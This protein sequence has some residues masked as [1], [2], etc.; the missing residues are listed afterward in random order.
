MNFFEHQ[1]AARRAS[2]RMVWLF[3]ASVL[4]IVVAIDLVLALVAGIAGVR[5]TGG[6][7]AAVTA[8]VLLVIFG[9]TWWQIRQ[10]AGGGEAVAALLGAR[11][12]D[13]S[14]GDLLERRLAN[15]VEE[16]A[17]ASGIAV[18]RCYLLEH[19][20]FINACAA[21]HTLDNAAVIVTRGA[22][23]RLSRD[24]LQGV[25]AHEFAH[26]VN[27]DMRLNLRLVGVTFGLLVVALA[28][29]KLIEHGPDSSDARASIGLLLVG[30]VLIAL[31]W[32]GVLCG[33][34][35]K[36]GVSRD[37][38]YLADASA[39]QFT[40]NPDSIGGALRKIG[41]LGGAGGIGPKVRADAGEVAAQL[42]GIRTGSGAD[43]HLRRST[44]ETFGH[45][46]IAPAAAAVE[47]GLFATH[48]PLAERV[49]RIYGRA[50]DW[51]PAPEQPVARALESASARELPPLEYSAASGASPVAGLVAA[52]PTV[53]AVAAAVG[54]A[55]ADAQ[56]GRALASR[57]DV[58]PLAEAVLD[59]TRAPLLVLALLIEKRNAVGAQQRQAIAEALGAAAVAEVESLHTAVQSLE[60]G[61]RLPLLDRAAP[62]LRKLPAS[63][64]ERLLLL[65][66]TLIAA[67]GKVTL[68]EFLLFTVLKRRVGSA[69]QR[70][71]PVRYAT[72][73]PLAAE[74]AQVL[75]LLAQVRRGER[76][77]SAFAAGAALLPELKLVMPPTMS[78]DA[79]SQALA[80]LAELAPLA[81][82]AFIKA[83]AAVAFVDG[84]TNW[85][86]ASCLRTVCA[87]LD[88][89]LPP[90][91]AVDQG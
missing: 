10:L 44:A 54:A 3:A 23:T 84:R 27:G 62:A 49:R 88:A 38:E 89:P 16:M 21:G 29:Q 87:A 51:L 40:R 70:A 58:P 22:L 25:I 36:A 59:S 75:A 43:E 41:G 57:L 83:C 15:I 34:A 77:E 67:D 73:A 68:P 76:A 66:H 13:P 45:M 11:A 39:V 12:V 9:G 32:L 91:L 24:E 65:A 2:R 86:A 46:F 60:P 81:K 48:P 72:L 31:G 85:Q 7:H 4:A 19:Q 53:T 79:V 78:L 52:A 37:R 56:A 20:R 28:G 61:L 63:S 64:G 90:Q 30:G 6:F 74:A 71:A 80:R 14:T 69:A 82:P 1:D 26:I 8:L 42:A 33:R 17:L 50:M 35:I 5:V 55:A 18:P 47:G